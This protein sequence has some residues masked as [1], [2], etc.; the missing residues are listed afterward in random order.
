MKGF[1]L[2]SFGSACALG[3]VVVLGLGCGGDDDGGG[4]STGLPKDQKLSQLEN[5]DLMTACETVSDSLANV[6]SEDESRRIDCT[7]QSISG[8]V[9]VKDGKPQGD[10]GKCKEL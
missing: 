3:C 1:G 6:I 8:S 10:V 4:V 5:E 7:A 2:R 9:V